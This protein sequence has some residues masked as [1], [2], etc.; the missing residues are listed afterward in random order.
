MPVSF[1]MVGDKDAI[2]AHG[3]ELYLSGG[4]GKASACASRRMI[5]IA[6]FAQNREDSRAKSLRIFTK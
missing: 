1:H 4:I 3:A 6:N 5:G 2:F